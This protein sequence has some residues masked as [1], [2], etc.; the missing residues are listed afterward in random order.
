MLAGCG[1]ARSDSGRLLGGR[2]HVA[3]GFR[4]S[5]RP[6]VRRLTDCRAP[7]LEQKHCFGTFDRDWLPRGAGTSDCVGFAHA[8]TALSILRTYNFWPLTA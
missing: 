1:T 3:K 5:G 2:K 7:E 4:R 6:A 8:R